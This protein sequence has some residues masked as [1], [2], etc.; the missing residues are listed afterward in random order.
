MIAL[1]LQ[2]ALSTLEVGIGAMHKSTLTNVAT[3]R[4]ETGWKHSAAIIPAIEST[5]KLGGYRKEN[6]DLMITCDGPGSYTGLRIGLAVIKGLSA[7][8][9]APWISISLLDAFAYRYQNDATLIAPLINTRGDRWFSSMYSKMAKI[10]VAYRLLPL[11]IVKQYRRISEIRGLPILWCGYQTSIFWNE[12]MNHNAMVDSPRLLNAS[13]NI[14]DTCEISS[15]LIKLGMAKWR[16]GGANH[17]NQG[18]DYSELSQA[19]RDFKD[20]N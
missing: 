13:D 9:G 2:T 19:E 17:I 18:I 14:C 7:G 11:E 16:D 10:S 5:L 1:A 20:R 3:T 6:I 15:D 4:I 8:I 12:G